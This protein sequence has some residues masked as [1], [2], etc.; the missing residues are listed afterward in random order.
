MKK[1]ETLVKAVEKMTVADFKEHLQLKEVKECFEYVNEENFASAISTNDLLAILVIKE[2]EK[3]LSVTTKNKNVYKL[4]ADVNYIK[5][6]RH[7]HSSYKLNECSLLASD[8]SRALHIYLKCNAKKNEVYC[9]ICTSCKDTTAKTF[10]NNF[11]AL[12]F[13]VKRDKNNCAKTSVRKKIDYNDI[14]DVSKLVLAVLND[15]Y[16]NESETE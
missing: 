14:V 9:D 12:Q 7:K 6:N 1:I 3:A 8:D 16:R 15:E 10:E 13:I 4:V 5:S 11:D 2:L